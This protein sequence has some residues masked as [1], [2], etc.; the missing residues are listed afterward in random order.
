MVVSII[1]VSAGTV[2]AVSADSVLSSV[3]V[4]PPPHATNAKAKPH[5]I[6]NAISFFIEFRFLKFAANIQGWPGFAG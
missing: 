6:S 2:I 1:D 3:V 5:T 4:E